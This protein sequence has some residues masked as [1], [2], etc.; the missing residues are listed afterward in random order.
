MRPGKGSPPGSHAAWLARDQSHIESSP[1]GY[2]PPPQGRA[3]AGEAPPLS[4]PA[5]TA[6]FLAAIE[7][8]EGTIEEETARLV[9]HQP[10]DLQD[11]NARKS[12]SLLELV[13]LGRMLPPA[14]DDAVRRRL[15]GLRAT[16]E[17]NRDVLKRNLDA[18]R[19]IGDLL[20]NALG[21]AE[22]DGTYRA[23]RHQATRR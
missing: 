23:P 2:A 9:G 15:G 3:A 21:E 18:V 6:A 12:R 11:F 14:V 20:L 17:R 19:E 7:R 4:P 13:R 5:A 1:R 16:L 10:I 22:S 8:I